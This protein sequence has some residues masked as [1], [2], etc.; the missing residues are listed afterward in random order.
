M[1]F[2]SDVGPAFIIAIA[3]ILDADV[4]PPEAGQEVVSVDCLFCFFLFKSEF[5]HLVAFCQTE[6]KAVLVSYIPVRLVGRG[7]VPSDVR[8]SS[9]DLEIVFWLDYC[10]SR[11]LVPAE[12]MKSFGFE[13]I[14]TS[15]KEKP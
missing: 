12:L 11:S 14:S 5:Y 1:V 6:N 8:E 10:E 15:P 3:G 9:E 13:S 7:L 2:R 4:R